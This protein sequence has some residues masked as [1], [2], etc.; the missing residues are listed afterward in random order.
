[1]HT[2]TGYLHTHGT[3]SLKITSNMANFVD[4]DLI[5]KKNFQ[6]DYLVLL[7]LFVIT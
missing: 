1:M 7:N 4:R 3:E 5:H 6:K 2:F